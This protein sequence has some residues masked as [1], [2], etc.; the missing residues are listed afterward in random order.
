MLLLSLFTRTWDCVS[1]TGPEQ[2]WRIIQLKFTKWLQSWS[3]AML[4]SFF[5]SILWNGSR[6]LK[7]S[8]QR[9]LCSFTVGTGLYTSSTSLS[10]SFTD[11]DVKMG[12]ISLSRYQRS[13][14]YF[15]SF[16]SNWNGELKSSYNGKNIRMSTIFNMKS[17]I[18]PEA[19]SYWVF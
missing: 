6:I 3:S 14:E 8:L 11:K 17:Q 12:A 16:Y 15:K 19:C 4:S 2:S 18:I 7:T 9:L 10:T 5:L 13:E 1:S